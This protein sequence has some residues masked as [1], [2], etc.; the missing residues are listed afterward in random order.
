MRCLGNWIRARP[1]LRLMVRNWIARLRHWRMGLSYVHPT[2]Y[3]ASSAVLSPD[4]RAGEY[5]FVNHGCSVG[6]RVILGRY[7]MLGPRASIVGADHVFSTA[8][9]PMI[10]AGRPELPETVIEDDAW[11]GFGAIIMAGVRVGRGAIVA[12][13][14]VVTRDVPAYEIHGGIP[15][16]KIGQRFADEEE[17]RIHDRMLNGGTYHGIFCG[18]RL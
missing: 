12:A 18:P 3:P 1:G 8:G 2:F 11:I 5:S 10:F 15:A 13:G 14:A 17:K 6:P 7:V 4:L 9:V 16:R